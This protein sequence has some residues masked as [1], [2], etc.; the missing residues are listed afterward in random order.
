MATDLC[1]LFNVREELRAWHEPPDQLSHEL[2]P[3]LSAVLK[4]ALLA[5][6]AA[7]ILRQAMP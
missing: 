3:L 4:L 7:I 6:T 5:V 2:H 1:E